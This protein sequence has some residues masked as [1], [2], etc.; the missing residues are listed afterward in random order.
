MGQL[1]E[2]CASV[3]GSLVLAQVSSIASPHLPGAGR[4]FRKVGCTRLRFQRSAFVSDK[5]AADEGLSCGLA[6]LASPDIFPDD[7]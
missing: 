4:E 6:L 7:R 1:C 3:A 2:F 5:E